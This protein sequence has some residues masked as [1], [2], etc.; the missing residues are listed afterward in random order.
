MD[1]KEDLTVE[2]WLEKNKGEEVE[3]DDNLCECATWVVG[4][5]RCSCGNVR[6]FIVKEDWGFYVDIG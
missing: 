5:N 4:E 2:E 1:S 3:M 6:P